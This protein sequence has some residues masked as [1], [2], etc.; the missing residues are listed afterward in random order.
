[1]RDGMNQVHDQLYIANITAAREEPTPDD[2][3]AVISVCQDEISDNIGRRYHHFNMSDGPQNGYGGDHSYEMFEEAA[4]TILAYLERE[5]TVLVHCH[6]GQSRS[7]STSIAA[8]GVLEG[9]DYHEMYDRVEEH[10]PQIHP[11][12]LL[13][14]HAQQFIGERVPHVS[15]APFEEERIEW[16]END[17]Y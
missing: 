11:D 5:G 15:H 2:V 3:D 12:S 7:A 16:R 9:V 6:A 8:L 1:M 4:L 14:Q 10:R 17:R 13:E